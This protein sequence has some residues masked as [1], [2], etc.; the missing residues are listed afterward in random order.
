MSTGSQVASE[1]NFSLGVLVACRISNIR[2][3]IQQSNHP[4]FMTAIIGKYLAITIKLRYF[5]NV[6]RKSNTHQRSNRSQPPQEYIQRKDIL[7]DNSRIK[8]IAS[9]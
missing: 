9:E 2:S 3:F 6:S 4:S 1:L 8:R 7:N 5:R